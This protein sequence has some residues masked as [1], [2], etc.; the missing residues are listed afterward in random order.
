VLISKLEGTIE[1]AGLRQDSITMRMTGCP[2]GCA[3]PWLAE[4][5]FVGKAY[6]AYNMYLG[7]GYHGQR[8]NKLY[9]SS[10]KE[11]EILEILKPMIKR[12]AAERNDGERFGDFVIRVGIIKPT[13][14]GKAFHEDVSDPTDST[15]Q[16]YT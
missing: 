7:G 2:N 12:Y 16:K 13:L 4:V 8:L 14:E 9:R 6:G 15:I 5:A 11:E 10:I 3:R 1:E